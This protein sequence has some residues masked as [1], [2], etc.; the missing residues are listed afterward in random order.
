MCRLVFSSRQAVQGRAGGGRAPAR[1]Q[2][3][4]R[5]QSSGEKPWSGPGWGPTRP[6]SRLRRRGRPGNAR[7]QASG[8]S[9]AVVGTV[10]GKG[11]LNTAAGG[12]QAGRL[13]GDDTKHA[14]RAGEGDGKTACG[15]RW[16][17]A[18]AAAIVHGTM[19]EHRPPCHTPK[20]ADRWVSRATDVLVPWRGVWA[21]GRVRELPMGPFPP[22]SSPVTVLPGKCG[23]PSV[24]RQRHAL[25]GGLS[26]RLE[27][28]QVLPHQLGGEELGAGHADGHARPHG[29]PPGQRD[30]RAPPR[31]RVQK[32]HG[33]RHPHQRPHQH[34]RNCMCVCVGGWGG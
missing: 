2:G 8:P 10:Q 31:Q 5:L 20:P 21:G 3:G 15:G 13:P 33:Y 4:S 30:A 23:P 22:N 12:N 7:P 17:G 26:E 25:D 34:K 14:Q 11:V 19:R 24:Q 1:K 29:R 6:G 28:G 16:Q 18:G 27:P 9:G 32:P